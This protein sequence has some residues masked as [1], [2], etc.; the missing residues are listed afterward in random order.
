M[1]ED[2][3]DPELDYIL[4]FSLQDDNQE[5]TDLTDDLWF[6]QEDDYRLALE[7]SKQW[8][9]EPPANPSHKSK[10]SGQNE[11]LSMSIVDPCLEMLDPNPDIWS[12]FA[13]FDDR[14]FKRKLTASGVQLSWSSSR[15]TST[16]GICSWSRRTQ[17]ASIRL[18]KPLLTLRPRSDTVET[19]LHEMI[20]AYLFVTHEDDN[21]ESH[22]N[23]FHFHMYR[24]VICNWCLLSR[25]MFC[26]SLQDQ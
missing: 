18:S 7:L 17:F 24:W 10:S 1:D 5:T 16:A 14:F 12:L 26:F 8:G 19:L 11:S 6:S 20:H 25:L 4:A 15:M 3:L 23:L 9:C 2:V 21:H 13:E 22:G